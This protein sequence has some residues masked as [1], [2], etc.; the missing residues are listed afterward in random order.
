[1][2]SIRVKMLLPVFVMFILFAGFMIIQ[3]SAI[4]N[5]L[6]QVREMNDKSFITLSKAEELKLS[7][8][9][10]QQWL[11][12]ISAT[13][14]AEGF[15]DGFGE[16]EKYSQNV[17]LITA[18]LLK[19]NPEKEVEINDI[20][21][22]FNPYY[23]TG[24]R[25]AQAY[26]EGGPDK[27]NL[28]MEEFDSTAIAINDNVD[29]FKTAS[30]EN[31]QY[32]I[33][34]IEESIQNTIILVIVSIG[35]AIIISILS[36]IYV[37][38]SIVNPIILVLSK[39]KEMANSEG[40]LTKHIDLI[41]QDEIGELA[42]S[43]NLMQDSFG[44]IISIINNESTHIEEKVINTN[45]TV[46]Q[47]SSL[48][49]EVSATTEE[50]STG[51]EESAAS[52][53]EMSASALEIE[54]AIES[55]STK[56]QEGAERAL[57]IS[58]RAN[59]LKTKAVNSKE[60]A[61][62]IYRTTQNKLVDAIERSKVVEKIGVLSES[63]LEIT[64]Q[65]N[66]LALNAAIEAARAGEAGRGFAVV[67]DEIR[68]LAENSKIAVSEI[69]NVTSIVVDSVQNLVTTSEEML[70]FISNQVIN[71]YEMLVVTGEQYNNDA[72][73]VSDMTADFSATSEQIMASV[74][75]VVKAINEIAHAS[76]ESA[77][78]ASSI[79]EKILAISEKSY[80]VEVQTQEVK[81][82]TNKLVEMC[83]KYKV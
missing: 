64:S 56:A 22:K 6:K 7:V 25:M 62:S 66:L 30:T 72:I 32:S 71:D 50:L 10:V 35:L 65:T 82:S 5:N 34:K 68:K 46:N 51:M 36:W 15:D 74:Q 29:T 45:Q 43:F 17:K 81:T 69:Q 33:T 54:S 9:Q 18:Q 77:S 49:E 44:K 47:L 20:E 37:T 59:E 58:D 63:I 55:I 26:I 21:K 13:R 40:D 60:T 48:I 23:E 31:I 79:A 42:E 1:M 38:R 57:L 80:N 16:A 83:S 39:L 19:I 76:N 61:N 27:G 14:G 4:N 75:T 53:E 73:M 2:K 12:D 28:L 3:I 70:G 24:K 41:R 67:A 52:T 78:G 8:V 11:T